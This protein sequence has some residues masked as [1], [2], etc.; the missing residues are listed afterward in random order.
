M[1]R[2]TKPNQLL[3]WRKSKIEHIMVSDTGAV[4]NSRTGR[5][6]KGSLKGN[7]T[8][9][10]NTIVDGRYISVTIAKLIYEAW[11]GPV[12]EGC[13][14]YHKDNIIE[15]NDLG[16][17]G[18][19]NKGKFQSMNSKKTCGRPVVIRGKDGEV[20]R[21]YKSMKEYAEKNY[22]HRQTLIDYRAGRT[23][24]PRSLPENIQFLKRGNNPEFTD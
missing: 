10:V 13:V 7:R 3:K 6:I 12:P 22:V 11:I 19:M 23:K 18:I 17:L 2:L 16:N 9:A 21:R 20:I 14:V 8:R 24:N 1:T 15:N 5:Y 4:W